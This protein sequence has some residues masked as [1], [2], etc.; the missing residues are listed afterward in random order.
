LISPLLNL[1][2]GTGRAAPTA[3]QANRRRERAAFSFAGALIA[4]KPGQG[5]RN[6][7]VAP[8]RD[9]GV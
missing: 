4:A 1:A 2:G 7:A 9:G 3:R 6:P 5:E 8:Q